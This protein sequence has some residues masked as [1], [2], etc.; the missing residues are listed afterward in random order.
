M[1]QSTKS[2][3]KKNFIFIVC[4]IFT[5]IGLCFSAGIVY[6]ASNYANQPPILLSQPQEAQDNVVS[7]MD[8]LCAGNFS[9][10]SQ[11]ILGTPDFGAES[12]PKDVVGVLIWDAYIDSMSYEL[13]DACYATDAGLA[14]KIRFTYLD[15]PS[16]TANLKETSGQML[17][18]RVETAA[19][20]TEVYNENLEY[21]EDVVME[22]LHEAAVSVIE[23]SSQT[24]S[25]D[26]IVTLINQNGHWWIVSDTAFMDS[27]FGNILF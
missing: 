1:Q 21:R 7:M 14:Q 16:I 18:A 11:Y 2:S 10:A 24:V 19:D 12:Q 26:I 17:E 25:V 9:G 20:I 4:I 23:Q 6:I 3:L 15:I 5:V 27:I 22:V 8:C 13:V